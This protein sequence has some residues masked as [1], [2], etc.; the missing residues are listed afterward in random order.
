MSRFRLN[1]YLVTTTASTAVRTATTTA[2]RTATIRISAATFVRRR[3]RTSYDH[4][5]VTVTSAGTGGC[6]TPGG[7]PAAPRDLA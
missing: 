1:Q 4:S 6:R 3:S 5:V 7:P 2:I